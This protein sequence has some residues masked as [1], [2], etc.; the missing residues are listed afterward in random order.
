MEVGRGS[1]RHVGRRRVPRRQEF[2]VFVDNL[3]QQLDHYGL[4]G[5][6]RKAENVSDVYVPLKKARRRRKFGFVRFWNQGEATQSVL[7]LNNSFV[8][9]SKIHV[10]MAKYEKKEGRSRHSTEFYSNN[11]HNLR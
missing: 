2:T 9:G 5:V 1:S 7:L 6:F 4:K 11:M 3:P 8:K 10:S